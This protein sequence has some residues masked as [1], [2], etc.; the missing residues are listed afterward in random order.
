MRLEEMAKQVGEHAARRHFHKRAGVAFPLTMGFVTPGI[1][2]RMHHSYTDAR[3]EMDAASGQQLAPDVAT[4]KFAGLS[5]MF[6]HLSADQRVYGQQQQQEHQARQQ[7]QQQQWQASQAPQDP[8]APSWLGA[9]TAGMFGTGKNPGGAVGKS[10]S[11]L[12]G[13]P[14]AGLATGIGQVAGKGLDRLIFG[15]E[16]GEKKDPMHMMGGAAMS[17]F[18]KGLGE[19]GADLLRDIASKAMSAAGN[20]GQQSARTAILHQLKTE[21]PV[22]STADDTVLMD[23]YHTMS[24]F[25]PVLS[26]DKNAVRSFLRQAVMSGGGA[27]FMSIKLLAD[28]ERAVTGDKERR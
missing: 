9:A 10:V 12:F 14:A 15:R 6:G 26:T 20:A 24:R 25:A 11:D 16:Y 7:Q 5:D 18:G 22:L 17:S 23:A 28:S 4:R 2:D 27:D 13:A 8:A 21:D 3:N 1:L 19:M